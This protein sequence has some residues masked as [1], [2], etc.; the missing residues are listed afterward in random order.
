MTEELKQKARKKAL[1]WNDEKINGK[2]NRPPIANWACYEKGY[3]AGATEATEELQEE[4][5]DIQQSCENYY[6]EMRSYKNKVADL[7]KQIEKMKCC[8]NCNHFDL[9]VNFKPFCTNKKTNIE[10]PVICK[11]KDWQ[12]AYED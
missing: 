10:N 8:H 12:F 7:E 5:K 9:D 1:E 3:I 2:Y 4:N 11:C 6:N